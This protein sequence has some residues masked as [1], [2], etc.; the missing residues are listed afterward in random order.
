MAS[1]EGAMRIRRV[2]AERLDGARTTTHRRSRDPGS[3]L[4]VVEGGG[5]GTGQ[6]G[7]AGRDP[8][9]AGRDPAKDRQGRDDQN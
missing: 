1:Q 8:A 9:K 5:T 6:R 4:T 7:K 3:N 2:P